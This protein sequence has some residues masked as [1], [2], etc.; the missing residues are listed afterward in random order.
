LPDVW[1]YGIGALFIATVLLF[2]RGLVGGLQSLSHSVPTRTK[3]SPATAS[4][5]AV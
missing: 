3:T 1:Q 5:V 2:P 4:K